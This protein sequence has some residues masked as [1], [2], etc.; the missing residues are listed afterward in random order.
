MFCFVLN[1]SNLFY[2]RTPS[3]GDL[4]V[5]IFLA[6][7]LHFKYRT[8]AIIGRSRLEAAPLRFQAKTHF[9]CRLYVVMLGLKK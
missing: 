2:N 5:T 1:L 6:Y 7:V 4:V 3:N 9:L 8:R